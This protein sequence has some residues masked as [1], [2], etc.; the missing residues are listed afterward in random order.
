MRRDGKHEMGNMTAS[1]PS[2][3]STFTC[4]GVPI[5]AV[6]FPVRASLQSCQGRDT[7]LRQV[8][9][10]QGVIH[11]II[12]KRLALPT[13][14]N[15]RANSKKRILYPDKLGQLNSYARIKKMEHPANKSAK[16]SDME[17]SQQ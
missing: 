4:H 13:R 9:F 16:K 5:S 11:C 1:S 7:I 17:P 6:P 10:E 15:V 12:T 8:P 2:T 3:I 14:A